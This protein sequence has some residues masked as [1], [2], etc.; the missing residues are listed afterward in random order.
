MGAAVV[1][2]VDAAPIFAPSEHVFDFVALLIEDGVVGDRDLSIGF[3]GDADGDAALCEG[4][5]E[6]I[7]VVPLSARSS[8]ALGMAGNISA[9]P[10]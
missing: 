8:L 5:A 7:G 1:S 4:G 10:L 6:P 9:A 3:R 2:G